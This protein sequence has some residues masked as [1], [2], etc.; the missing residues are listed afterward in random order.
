MACVESPSS[1]SSLNSKQSLHSL[2]SVHSVHSLH[3]AE[4]LAAQINEALEAAR[5]DDRIMTA[6]RCNALPAGAEE[7]AASVE[8]DGQAK[9]GTLCAVLP[10]SLA[11]S[12]VL[13]NFAATSCELPGQ[14]RQ[15]T[16][17]SARSSG[18]PAAGSPPGSWQPG[19]LRMGAA[20]ASV[21]FTKWQHMQHRYDTCTDTMSN[22]LS[23]DAPAE[24][25][26][27]KRAR[28]EESVEGKKGTSSSAASPALSDEAGAAHVSKMAK[29]SEPVPSPMHSV[30]KASIEDLL[31]DILSATK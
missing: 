6:L 15:G 10:A 16:S 4:N 2:H 23:T 26:L 7:G 22:G 11:P 27:G 13:K 20:V 29:A 3:A 24:S 21:A 17:A 18:S 12:A 1:H 5:A 14:R 30:S 31:V 9:I 8:A 25:A 19:I 28:S